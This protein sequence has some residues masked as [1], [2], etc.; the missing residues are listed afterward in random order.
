MPAPR[1]LKETVQDHYGKYHPIVDMDYLRNTIAARR[2]DFLNDFDRTLAARELLL[3]NIFVMSR[4]VFEHY[5]E[6]LFDLTQALYENPPADFK[7][8]TAYDARYI[9]FLGERLLT[10]YVPYALKKF[11]HLR[12]QHRTMLLVDRD[13][14]RSAGPLRQM[15]FVAK[16]HLSIRDMIRLF[17][18]KA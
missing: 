5:S 18:E 16:G 7:D 1:Q 2:P 9:G 17:R 8:R 12:V 4:P 3:G 14:L 11:S 10:A 15:R 13:T 6:F